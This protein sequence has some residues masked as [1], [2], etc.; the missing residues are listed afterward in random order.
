MDNF[1]DNLDNEDVP[2]WPGISSLIAFTT[3]FPAFLS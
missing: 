1:L 2:F 3:V